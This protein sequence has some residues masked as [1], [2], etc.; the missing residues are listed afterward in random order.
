MHQLQTYVTHTH[1]SLRVVQ[2]TSREVPI[3]APTHEIHVHLAFVFVLVN[4]SLDLRIIDNASHEI[5]TDLTLVGMW[6]R[7]GNRI[8]NSKN[9]L[10]AG[11]V[12]FPWW[13]S[14][15][16]ICDFPSFSMIF[17]VSPSIPWHT[18][19]LPFSTKSPQQNPVQEMQN[20]R[21]LPEV[22]F[23][24]NAE[25]KYP[26]HLHSETLLEHIASFL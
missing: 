9:C 12:V 22:I 26:Q 19:S 1:P 5:A 20:H 17:S 4:H 14:S 7:G 11:F 24:G 6:N 21:I 2:Q 16:L 23:N 8:D 3:T 18:E 13:S 10:P 25:R 15:K